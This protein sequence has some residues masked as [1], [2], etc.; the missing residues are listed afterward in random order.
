MW[1]DLNF[2][3]SLF[4]LYFAQ[5]ISKDWNL[6]YNMQLAE[7]G[8]SFLHTSSWPSSVQEIGSESM[9]L[10]IIIF[11]NLSFLWLSIA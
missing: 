7:R 10:W 6:L 2:N 5:I 1:A 9:N 3:S 4:P 11:Y 8:L